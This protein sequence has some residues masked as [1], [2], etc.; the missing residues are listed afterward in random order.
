MNMRFA[1]CIALILLASAVFAQTDKGPPPQSAPIIWEPP[2]W[3]LPENVKASVPKELVSILRVSDYDI[4]LEET[5]MKD[6]QQR[7]GGE[8]GAKGDA[9]DA[10]EWLCFHGTDAMGAWVLWLESGEIDGGY[11]GSFQWQR[12]SGKEI[13]DRNC[14]ALR[15]TASTIK[16]PLPLR[17]GASKAEVVKVLGPPTSVNAERLIYF[18]EHEGTIKGE[19]F[20]SFNIVVLHLRKG[21]V[22]AIQVSKT[23]SS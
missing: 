6:A 20:T 8:I 19:P 9:G 2:D 10:L 11:V 12:L 21:I 7:L 1:T 18:H 17:L 23:T 3:S 14:H 13:F 16:L 22:R 5:S 4:T 15:G